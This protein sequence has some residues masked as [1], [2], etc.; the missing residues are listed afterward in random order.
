[1]MPVTLRIPHQ[2]RSFVLKMVGNLTESY[3]GGKKIIDQ[4][5]HWVFMP[6]SDFI[7][8]GSCFP[9]PSGLSPRSAQHC[10]FQPCFRRFSPESREK[11]PHSEDGTSDLKLFLPLPPRVS[12]L[13][14][15]CLHALWRLNAWII[16]IAFSSFFP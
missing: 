10:L 7:R 11:M 1:M 6:E 8:H 4:Q 5:Q 9:Y 14:T 13:N 16:N 15:Q 12:I 2:K 3:F